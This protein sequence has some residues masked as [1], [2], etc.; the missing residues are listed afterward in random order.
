MFFS[1]TLEKQKNTYTT[2]QFSY[3][4]WICIHSSLCTAIIFEDDFAEK[5]ELRQI[6]Y[7]IEDILK[8]AEVVDDEDLQPIHD[9][10][11]S[12]RKSRKAAKWLRK[13]SL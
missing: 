9:I 4:R 2:L 3:K 10:I 6:L 13:K 12:K 7:M 8:E 5:K 1:Q 11:E